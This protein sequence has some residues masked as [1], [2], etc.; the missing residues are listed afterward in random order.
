[1]TNHMK[2]LVKARAEEGLWMERVPVPEPGP[3]ARS[4]DQSPQ[5]CNLR[6]R[7]SYLE[8]GRMVGEDCAR[9]HGGRS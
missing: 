3:H 6:H 8:M 4:A 2:A 9:A 5:I 7:C 1:M